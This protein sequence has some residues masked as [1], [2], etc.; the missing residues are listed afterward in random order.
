M[1]GD[2][3]Q[4]AEVTMAP[5]E[6]PVQPL[7][8]TALPTNPPTDPGEGGIPANN[9]TEASLAYN[10]STAMTFEEANQ[11]HDTLEESEQPWAS[12]TVKGDVAYFLFES[13]PRVER[14]SLATK[15]FL[16]SILLPDSHGPASAL[17]IDNYNQMYVGYGPK[18]FRYDIN[19]TNEEEIEVDAES[20][21]IGFHFDGDL[22]FVNAGQY[23]ITVNGRTNTLIKQFFSF[24]EMEFTTALP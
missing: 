19:G 3:L 4:S 16:P 5:S 18:V 2:R 11:T 15:S 21:V 17:G 9:G 7:E 6:A 8:A 13:L 14:Y 12:S 10:E 22:V 23:F 24:N 20:N 1:I